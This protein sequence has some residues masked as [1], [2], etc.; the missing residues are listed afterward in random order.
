MVDRCRLTKPVG[1]QLTRRVAEQLPINPLTIPDQVAEMD[2]SG[3]QANATVLAAAHLVNTGLQPE[4]AL[5]AQPA[6][7]PA[8]FGMALCLPAH[9]IFPHIFW[10]PCKWQKKGGC[11]PP[12]INQ[13]RALRPWRNA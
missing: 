3:R 6:I 11:S 2:R 13:N 10:L 5:H 7:G 4:Q 12:L 9:Q 8:Q 1:C